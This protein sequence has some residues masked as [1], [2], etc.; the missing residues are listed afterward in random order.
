MTVS[1]QQDNT[2]SLE[3]AKLRKNLSHS[4]IPHIQW[5]SESARKLNHKV[6]VTLSL[7]YPPKKGTPYQAEQVR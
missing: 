3:K 6:N 4:K 2:K 1:L 7:I 5:S